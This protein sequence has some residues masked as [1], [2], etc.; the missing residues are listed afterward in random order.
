MEK[1]G[2][3]LEQIN[4][5]LSWQ[6]HLQPRLKSSQGIGLL[7]SII[8]LV[9]F[10]Y[11]LSG[12]ILTGSITW[13]SSQHF[14]DGAQLTDIVGGHIGDWSD[15]QFTLYFPLNYSETP[16]KYRLA[17]PMVSSLAIAAWQGSQE[18]KQTM[19]RVL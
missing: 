2:I 18:D 12:P 15:Q 19:K 1:G 10:P 6:V 3:S 17:K 7:V 4:R 9:A 5:L 16:N 11:Q 13:S 14:T 8:L